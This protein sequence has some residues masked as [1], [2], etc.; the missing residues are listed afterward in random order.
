M[1]CKEKEELAFRLAR[2]RLPLDGTEQTGY[3][4]YTERNWYHPQIYYMAA[5]DCYEEMDKALG[6]TRNGR[7]VIEAKMTSD[8]N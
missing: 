4:T 6:K 8:N 1:S 2:P 7:I 5:M 3:V